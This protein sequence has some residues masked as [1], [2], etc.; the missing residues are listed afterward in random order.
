MANRSQS[1]NLCLFLDGAETNSEYPCVR[2][3]RQRNDVR[4]E[5]VQGFN[6]RM[7]IRRRA[8]MNLRTHIHI[9]L[10]KPHRTGG[11]GEYHQTAPMR[12]VGQQ[13]LLNVLDTAQEI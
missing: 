6:Q 4:F 8:P 3:V 10:T 7:Q 9:Y 1:V 13:K 12:F 2:A 5:L 11:P